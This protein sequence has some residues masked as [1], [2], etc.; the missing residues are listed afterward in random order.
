MALRDQIIPGLTSLGIEPRR[1]RD[2]VA[3]PVRNRLAESSV[4]AQPPRQEVAVLAKQVSELTLRVEALENALR[5]IAWP[6]LAD[7]STKPKPKRD[8]AEY[9]RERRKKEKAEALAS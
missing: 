8:R 7:N 3:Q 2:T 6:R 9:Y 5:D 1:H 4:V